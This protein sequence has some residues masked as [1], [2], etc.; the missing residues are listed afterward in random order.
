LHQ[1][2][3][4]SYRLCPASHDKIAESAKRVQVTHPRLRFR[5]R[6]GFV[7]F[8]VCGAQS[9]KEFGFDG[10]WN[11]VEMHPFFSLRILAF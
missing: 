4:D 9:V 2:V 6:R 8:A 5:F 11:E 1:E 3:D 7:V 10:F